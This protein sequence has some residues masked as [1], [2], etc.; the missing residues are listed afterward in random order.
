MSDGDSVESNQALA[1]ILLKGA[2]KRGDTGDRMELE[3]RGS[4]EG[5]GK[6][7]RLKKK[8]ERTAT[9]RRRKQITAKDQKMNQR[10]ARSPT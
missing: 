3:I 5:N 4:L 6:V 1:D 9:R 10:K 7:L 8:I 2:I